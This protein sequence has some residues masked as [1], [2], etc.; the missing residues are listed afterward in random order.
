MGV[1]P[2]TADALFQEAARCHGAGQ[3]QQAEDLYRQVLAASPQHVP[4]L[5]GLADLALRFGWAGA[6]TE[7]LSTA[8]R[9]RPADAELH[10]QLARS[11]Q[12]QGAYDDAVRSLQRAL[13]IQPSLAAAADELAEVR[14]EQSLAADP[15]YSA[16]PEAPW[17]A[18]DAVWQ[19]TTGSDTLLVLFAGLGVGRSPPT[20]VFRKFLR[21]YTN[22]DKLYVRD[23][24]MSWY[25]RGL[26]GLTSDVGTTLAWL[27]HKTAA[28]Q[29]VVFIGTSAG[30][31][32]A[33][34]YGELLGVH[35]VIAFAP[36]AVLSNRKPAELGDERWEGRL[37][38]LRAATADPAYLDVADLSPLR[39][40]LDIY[41][42]EGNDLDRAH[43]ERLTGPA[44]AR[45]PQP[46]A[47]HLVALDMRDSGAL[48]L[49]IERELPQPD[50]PA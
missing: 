1:A 42:P 14:R 33:I 22:V 31:T 23:Q 34:L 45:W 8:V 15:D 20:F 5:A 37:A 35:K 25:L 3:W 43:A 2:D 16:L 24:T 48:R 26:P 12:A 19:E 6:A 46:G 28:Y 39:V 30:A 49:V 36:Q 40:P 9:L 38:G 4:A 13:E 10:R 11:M 7:L 29:R 50:N 41:Y 27:R 17:A 32:A 18:D 21:R 47:G 44:V